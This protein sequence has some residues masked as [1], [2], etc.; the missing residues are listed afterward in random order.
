MVRRLAL[1]VISVALAGLA[2]AARAIPPAPA[3]TDAATL[4]SFATPGSLDR[5]ETRFV[6]GGPVVLSGELLL[7]DGAG[8]FPVVVLAHGCGGRTVVVGPT[9]SGQKRTD[10]CADMESR[11][12]PEDENTHPHLPSVNGDPAL[13]MSHHAS[14]HVQYWK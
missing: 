10:L 14:G 12:R 13:K 5:A 6:P 2:T 7:P 11:T 1:F 4:L 3:V 8:P 9:E